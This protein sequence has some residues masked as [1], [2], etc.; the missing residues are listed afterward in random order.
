MSIDPNP[1]VW[2]PVLWKKLHTV[3]FK[4][5]AYID[6]KNPEDVALKN[7][8]RKMFMDLRS[9]IPCK[10]CRVSY[11]SYI[12]QYP[13]EPHLNSQ[14]ALSKWLY[15]I[16][17]M[18]NA[19]LR[20]EESDLFKLKMQELDDYARVYRIS[21]EQRKHYKE[22]L[23]SRIMITGPDPTYQQVKNMYT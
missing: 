18:V 23:K 9:A 14:D 17:N 22:V 20:K 7:R 12:K 11:R 1:K 16:H 8:V 2:G 21:P 15:D 3:T 19:K 6:P 5:P 13:I 4:Y 10:K